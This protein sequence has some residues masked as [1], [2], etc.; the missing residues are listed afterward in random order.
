[1][2]LLS[3]PL[4]SSTTLT[5]VLQSAPPTAGVGCGRFWEMQ[6]PPPLFGYLF[7]ADNGG[8]QFWGTHSLPSTPLQIPETS[9]QSANNFAFFQVAPS[10]VG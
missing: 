2:Q 8:S 10:D 7:W 5:S 3:S 1:M 9:V 6:L 4:P